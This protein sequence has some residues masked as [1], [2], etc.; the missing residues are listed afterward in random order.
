MSPS[1]LWR[2]TDY[3]RKDHVLP[4]LGSQ[5]NVRSGDIGSRVCYLPSWLKSRKDKSTVA[6]VPVGVQGSDSRNLSKRKTS[7][8]VIIWSTSY[9]LRSEARYQRGLASGTQFSSSTMY[10]LALP[11]VINDIVN[12]LQ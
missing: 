6:A 10:L 5:R 4:V 3:S 11:G 12:K 8:T 1:A 2:E 7:S 9:S